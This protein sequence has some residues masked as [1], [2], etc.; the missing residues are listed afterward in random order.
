MFMKFQNRENAFNKMTKDVE[1][2]KSELKREEERSSTFSNQQL[3]C[4][5]YSLFILK[6]M[7]T[8]FMILFTA[9]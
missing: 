4:L 6:F 3:V 1:F 8:I 9:L 2:T 7:C 5:Q